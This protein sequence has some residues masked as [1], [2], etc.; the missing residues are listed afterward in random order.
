[1]ALATVSS[2][3]L[4]ISS[5]FF[6]SNGTICLH[7]WSYNAALEGSHRP[8][9]FMLSGYSGSSLPTIC[10]VGI[11]MVYVSGCGV[12][13]VIPERSNGHPPQRNTAARNNG[14]AC[15]FSLA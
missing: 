15:G 1:M 3:A 11:V 4:D 8:Y 2:I 13:N 12:I 9:N 10:A 5:V 6:A 7:P 14:G